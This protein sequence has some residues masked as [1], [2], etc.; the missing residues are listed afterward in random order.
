LTV[1]V[2]GS[3]G[4]LYMRYRTVFAAFPLFVVALVL[5]KQ[6]RVYDN[7]GIFIPFSESLDLCLRQSIPLML[8]SLVLLTFS[9][10]N[11]A[12][13]GNASFW[14]WRNSTPSFIDFAQNDLMIGTQ[15][16]FFLFLIPLIGVVCIG[17]CTVL[18]YLTLVL[19][20]VL[21]A[22]ISLLTF[23][24]GWIRNEDKK[25]SAPAAFLPSSPRRRAITTTVLLFLVSTVIPY[26]FAY[27]VACLVQLTTT[28]RAQRIASELR[29]TANSNF[30][31]YIHSILILMLWILPIN[32]P[33]LVVWVR[34][35]AVHWLTPFT[36][37]HNI[38]SIMP[39]IVLVETLTTGKM[40]PRV[41]NRLKHV[42]SV[43]LFG[44]AVCAAVYGVSYAY[45]LHNLANLVAFW[46][47]I[48]HS[49]SD[50]WSLADISHLYAGNA[51]DRK[52]GKEP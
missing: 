4:K 27:L 48:L 44:I 24:P 20:Q 52:R 18:N 33:T 34:N 8:T 1:D 47:A 50:S 32:L 2:L 15:D 3:L 14:H 43:L 40:I 31:N 23:S 11:T 45:R 5:R 36:S 29:S 35:L 25:K 37:H 13:A 19:T 22:V 6:F 51:G 41:G 7:T 21:S 39:F 17:V 10:A 12:P 49:A 9:T 28:V 46:L 42:T 26:Q 16:P 38:L 30:Y